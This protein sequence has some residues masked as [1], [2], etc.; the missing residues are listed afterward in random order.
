MS[1][2]SRPSEFSAA[3]RTVSGAEVVEAGEFADLGGDDDVVAVAARRHPFADDRLRLAAAVARH[4]GHVDVGGVDEVAAAGEEAIEHGK[5]LV[6][7]GGPAEHVAAE[8]E[9]GDVEV[10][11]RDLVI[12]RR[13]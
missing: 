12:G 6:A 1:I 7:V 4:A 2:P 5:R 3:V 9:G 13:L 8:A 10:G 11:A